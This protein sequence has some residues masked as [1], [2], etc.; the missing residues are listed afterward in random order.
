MATH[1]KARQVKDF[2]NHRLPYTAHKI[3]CAGIESG[4]IQWKWETI[5]RRFPKC[6]F[7]DMRTELV[8]A[9]CLRQAREIGCGKDD[10]SVSR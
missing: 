10:G 4:E 8:Q 9:L 6:T 5:K 7:N 1:S 3:L 2:L